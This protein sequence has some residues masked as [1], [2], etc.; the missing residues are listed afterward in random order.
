MITDISLEP[1]LNS[2]IKGRIAGT[3]TNREV[4]VD[5]ITAVSITPTAG[6]VEMHIFNA[7]GVT[8]RYGGVGLTTSTG[9]KIFAQGTMALNPTTTFVIYVMSESSSGNLQVVEFY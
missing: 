9:G 7:L 8:V 5:A 6:C 1:L 3:V 4:A 2:R